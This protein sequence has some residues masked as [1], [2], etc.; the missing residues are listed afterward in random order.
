MEGPIC[1]RSRGMNSS[2]CSEEG[3]AQVHKDGNIETVKGNEVQEVRRDQIVP[4]LE[5]YTQKLLD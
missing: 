5:N 3:Q 1:T 2:A 4:S